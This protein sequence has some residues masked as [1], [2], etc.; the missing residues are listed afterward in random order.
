[1][2]LTTDAAP[3]LRSTVAAAPVPA[4]HHG[5]VPDVAAVEVDS[6]NAPEG[7]AMPKIPGLPGRGDSGISLGKL[8]AP[9][10]PGSV[11]DRADM[12][13]VKGAQKLRTAKG[14]AWADTMARTGAFQAWMAFARQH[15]ATSGTVRGWL[16]TA[17]LGTV[18]AATAAV[19]QIAKSKYDRPRPFQVDPSIKPP[20]QLPRSASY[21]SG[22]SSS[23]FAGARVIARV[24][25]ELAGDAYKLATQVAA[26]RVY[27]GVHYPT[28][29]VMGALLGTGVADAILNAVH[30]GHSLR[31]AAAQVVRD[32]RNG[33]F[34]AAAGAA[35]A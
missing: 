19:T 15:R 32:A 29:V 14:D 34:D 27:A 20:V 18:L 33:A 6:E 8:L 17:L 2:H 31:D 24:A 13:F 21:P 1:M 12:A 22:H 7:I 26:S 4:A 9:P 25:P 11:A 10:K 23:A 3:A 35:A 16:D 5:A 28:D 30:R